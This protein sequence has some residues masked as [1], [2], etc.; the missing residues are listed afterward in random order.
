MWTGPLESRIIRHNALGVHVLLPLAAGATCHVRR[1]GCGLYGVP[2][3]AATP[4]RA[5]GPRCWDTCLR[6]P[7]V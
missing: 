2:Q 7:R 6:T 3:E 4:T 1:V 5:A